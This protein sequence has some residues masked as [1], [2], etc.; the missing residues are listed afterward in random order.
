MPISLP[1]ACF[2][3]IHC[4][5]PGVFTRWRSRSIPSPPESA[6]SRAARPLSRST[7]PRCGL[8]LA[9]TQSSMTSSATVTWCANAGGR[10]RLAC[11]LCTCPSL[12]AFKT[13]RG[14][15]L[16]PTKRNH[17][18]DKDA[19]SAL[20]LLPPFLPLALVLRCSFLPRPSCRRGHDAV[21]AFASSAPG[22]L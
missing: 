6:H 2:A 10:T 7:P 9:S 18:R 20:F 3:F 11:K 22:Q 17:H 16:L 14:F 19:S 8:P 5:G 12:A 21:A 13:P 1:E 4:L 15:L